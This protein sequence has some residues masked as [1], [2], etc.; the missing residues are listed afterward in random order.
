ML[1][2]T[3]T[4]V[5]MTMC[6]MLMAGAASFAA[7][8]PAVLPHPQEIAWTSGGEAWL[9]AGTLRLGELPEAFAGARA[10]HGRTAAKLGA[11]AGAKT[12]RIE[13]GTLPERVAS[14]TRAEGYAL[15]I[16]PDGGLLTAETAHGAH[17]GLV[18]LAGLVGADGRV[19]H[20]AIL[21]WPD[22]EMRGTYAPSADRVDERFDQFVALKLNLL[23]L[24]DGALFSLDQPETRERFQKLAERCRENFIEFVPELQ[25]LGWGHFVLQRVPLAVEAR[26]V[27]RKPFTVAGGRVLSP[28]QPMPPAPQVLNAG[29]AAGMDGWKAQTH[30]KMW[31]PS[32][33]A[34]ASAVPC[35]GCPSGNALRTVCTDGE[36]VRVEQI[37]AV[38]PNAHYELRGMVKTENV[39]GNGAYIE[40]YGVDESGGITEHIGHAKGSVSG[41]TDW[42]EMVAPF[43]TGAEGRQRPGGALE[44]DAAGRAH[45]RVCLFLRLEKSTGTAWFSGVEVRPVKSPNPLGNVVV[46][47]A[48][49]V[50]VRGAGGDMLFEEGRDYTLDIPELRY[51]FDEGGILGVARTPDS[52][53]P[54]EGTV[55][56]SYNQAGRDDI[57]CCPSEPLYRDFLRGA[58][59]NVVTHLKPKYLHIG[60][61]EPRFF[62]RDQRCA[63]R[64]MSNTE[65]FVDDIKRTREFALEADPELRLMIWDDAINPYQNGPSLDTSDAAKGLPRDIIVNVW[66]YDNDQW[67]DQMDRSTDYFLDL[68]FE[69]TGSPWFRVPNAFHWAELFNARRD[70]PSALGVI[71]TSWEDL[72]NPWAALEFTAEHLWSF[73]KPEYRP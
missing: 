54:E 13:Q 53:I 14:R 1:N 67:E 43:S 41:T 35:A 25:S 20:A 30:R 26:W 11:A 51:P 68:G 12:L 2:R 66:W 50:E 9:D 63:D 29:F 27:D 61:D 10:S 18:T 46:T 8:P 28:N 65:L 72:P 48:A 23:V 34:E 69:V 70:N 32:T 57:T 56:L 6:V 19:P 59:Q 5:W 64:G 4:A 36:N 58:I 17:N 71:Y 21:D 45:E 44:G 52:R 33:E 42:T 47:E 49:R 24:E 73:N 7:P 62:N 38:E 22:Q 31:L 37:V 40:V 16:G 55:L 15:T 60:H 3:M 39:T